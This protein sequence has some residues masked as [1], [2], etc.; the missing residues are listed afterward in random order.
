MTQLPP[1]PENM[2]DARAARAAAALQHFQIA[3]CAD[4][5][6][7]V[8]DLLCDLMHWCDRNGFDFQHELDRARLHYEAET[9]P[10]DMEQAEAFQ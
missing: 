5:Q 7:A 10:K 4:D 3:T 8:R 9:M 2:N 6:D 1:D